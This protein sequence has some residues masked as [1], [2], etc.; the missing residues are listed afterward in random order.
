MSNAV[1]DPLPGLVDDYTTETLLGRELRAQ[2]G[3]VLWLDFMRFRD[4]PPE[5]DAMP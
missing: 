5:R 2:H 4:W 1:P 3:P